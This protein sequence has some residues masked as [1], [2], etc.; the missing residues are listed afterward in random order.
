MLSLAMPLVQDC[1]PEVP[2]S[3]ICKTS[4]QPGNHQQDERENTYNRLFPIET[5]KADDL[6]R[7][8]G[9]I[10]KHDQVIT[11]LREIGNGF[12]PLAQPL[13]MKPSGTNHDWDR[14]PV[15][16]NRDR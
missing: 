9:S 15:R 13:K 14:T 7:Y 4:T 3:R 11:A 16:P 6:R 12:H 2:A 10:E 1:S 8:S 5:Q